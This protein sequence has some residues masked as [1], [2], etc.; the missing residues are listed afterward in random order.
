V[1]LRHVN[2][3]LFAAIIVVL[4]YVVVAPAVPVVSFWFQRHATSRLQQLAGQLDVPA[5]RVV[6]PRDDRLVI[7]AM[8]LSTPINEGQDM[9]ALRTGPWRRPGSSTPE[10]GGNTVIVGHRFTYTNPRG[11]FY[12]LDKLRPGDE[13]GVFWHGKRY[14]YRVSNV[15]VKPPTATE[16]ESPTADDRLTL[17]TC[18]PLWLPKDRLVVT[19]ELESHT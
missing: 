6:A 7:P 13:I 18:T 5:A 3:A 1:K 16:I 4:T 12:Y 17:Y 10:R 14:L 2:N 9:S 8:L 15:A 11:A 19:A